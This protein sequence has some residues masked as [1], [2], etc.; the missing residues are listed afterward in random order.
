MN[1]IVKC[2]GYYCSCILIVSFF[3]YGALIALISNKNYWVIRD[4]P[5]DTDSKIEALT[6]AIVVN[7]VCLAICVSCTAYGTMQERKQ[8]ALED[9]DD[10]ANLEMK[11]S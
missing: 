2:C 9:H 7:V 3:F 4:F 8:Q 6:I 1:P 5:H 10:D 11:Q